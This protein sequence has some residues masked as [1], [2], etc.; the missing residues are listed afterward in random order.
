MPIDEIATLFNIPDLREALSD[1]IQRIGNANH[2][3]IRVLGGC[4]S[5][6]RGSQL[7]FTHLQVWKKVLLQNKVYHSSG[8]ILLH[9]FAPLFII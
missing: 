6:S 1:Y 2:G 8:K 3:Y 5:A 4:R 9:Y 7:P